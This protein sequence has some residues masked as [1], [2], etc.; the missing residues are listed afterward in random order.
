MSQQ[1]TNNGS[2]PR[3]G[4]PITIWNYHESGEPKFQSECSPDIRVLKHRVSQGLKKSGHSTGKH[5]LSG[6]LRIVDHHYT[7]Y[8]VLHGHMKRFVPGIWT[9]SR[10]QWN[11][12]PWWRSTEE[13]HDSGQAVHD[14]PEREQ[15]G[16]LSSLVWEV[17]DSFSP[18]V[19][20]R[21]SYTVVGMR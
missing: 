19:W 12:D 16:D 3:P 15:L 10:Q 9:K 1:D 11:E 21:G 13:G 7:K 5:S 8:S 6:C 4:K 20:R 2:D 14:M 18:F 17:F